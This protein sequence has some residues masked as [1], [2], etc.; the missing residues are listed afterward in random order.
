MQYAA[1]QDHISF[2]ARA[3]MSLQRIKIEIL[4]TVYYAV[5]L[6]EEQPILLPAVYSCLK[7]WK[8]NDT[9]DNIEIALSKSSM[10]LMS[11]NR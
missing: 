4:F 1:F 8:P 2:S 6:L 7:S 11:F 5:L 9:W 3:D 10:Q